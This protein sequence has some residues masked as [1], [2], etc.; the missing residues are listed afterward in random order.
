MQVLNEVNVKN[1]YT[2]I[3]KVYTRETHYT[4]YAKQWATYC[5]TY[6]FRSRITC[7]FI[8]CFWNGHEWSA[9]GIMI[10]QNLPA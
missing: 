10:D 3:L 2:L 9:S 4:D 6:T 7:L 5:Y 8:S 1:M